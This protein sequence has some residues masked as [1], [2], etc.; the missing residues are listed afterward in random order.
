LPPAVLYQPYDLALTADGG[1]P[2]Y[3]WDVKFDYP[4]TA[5]TAPFPMVTAQ[6]LALTSNDEG[7]AVK[8]IGFDFPFYDKMVNEI[9]IYA[10]GFIVFD[11][12]PY[13]RPYQVDDMLLFR[14]TS[15]IAP[16]LADLAVYPS[17]GQ[18]SG[19]KGMP[20]MPFSGGKLPSATCREA[21]T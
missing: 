10:N 5:G 2:P 18:E 20:A 7:Y 12:Q 6:Q 11:D 19:T 13:H 3:L 1:T 16:F 9:Y 17:S 15:L 4:E 8:T 21:P 14:Q